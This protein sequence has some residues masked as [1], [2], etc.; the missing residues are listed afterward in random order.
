MLAG[1]TFY[2]NLFPYFVT[3][4]LELDDRVRNVPRKLKGIVAL[5][6][7]TFAESS[8]FYSKGELFLDLLL[9]FI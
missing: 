1:L 9:E 3:G 4:R 6:L 7:V 8:H 5:N 2:C